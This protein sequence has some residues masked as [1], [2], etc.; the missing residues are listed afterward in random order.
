LALLGNVVK[1]SLR[2][3]SLD[4]LARDARALV[5]S[6]VEGRQLT[7]LDPSAYGAISNAHSAGDLFDS[8]GKV[9]VH[10]CAKECQRLPIVQELFLAFLG[11]VG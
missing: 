5:R 6:N 2:H 4:R 1:S 9:G 10:C 3:K 7:A 11:K 8:E